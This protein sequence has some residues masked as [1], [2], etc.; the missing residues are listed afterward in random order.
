M[1]KSRTPTPYDIILMANCARLAL[2]HRHWDAVDE[3]LKK[4]RDMAEEQS[5]AQE[6][7]KAG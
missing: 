7:E 3:A 4:I 6:L 2:E 5:A 1:N